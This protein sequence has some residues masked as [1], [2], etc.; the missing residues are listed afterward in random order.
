MLL[1]KMMT[2]VIYWKVERCSRKC[3]LY[4]LTYITALILNTDCHLKSFSIR[5]ISPETRAVRGFDSIPFYALQN[6]CC[7]FLWDIFVVM[8]QI[9]M[10][11]Y[12]E[13]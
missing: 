6:A 1:S 5:I 11:Q 13:Y 8:C 7:H 12:H 4:R 10:F 2:E 9:Y 3:S